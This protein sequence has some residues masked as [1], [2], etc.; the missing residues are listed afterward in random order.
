MKKQIISL[1]ILFSLSI[2]VVS[3]SAFFGHTFNSYEEM[4]NGKFGFPIPFVYQDLI[5]S[6]LGYEGGF[7]R[8]FGI[9]MDFLDIDPVIEFNK[10][11][12]LLSVIIVY[13]L[14]TI[15]YFIRQKMK[16]ETRV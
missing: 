9:Q 15:I 10:L 12:F 8:S 6:G 14:F 11:Q 13:C 3:F 7:P 2:F 1:F 16:R 5:A 4:H